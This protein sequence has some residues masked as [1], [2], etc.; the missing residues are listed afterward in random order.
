MKLQAIVNGKPVEEVKPVV[1]A[2]PANR[3]YRKGEG[4]IGD[5]EFAVNARLTNGAM[6]YARIYIKVL[7][8]NNNIEIFYDSR[9]GGPLEPQ[10][11]VY[12]SSDKSVEHAKAIHAALGVAIGLCEGDLTEWIM[13]HTQ[14]EAE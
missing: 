2:A 11:G 5:T 13:D 9:Y 10:I 1:T 4:K 6:D 7:G 3:S 12:S 8:T 14:E